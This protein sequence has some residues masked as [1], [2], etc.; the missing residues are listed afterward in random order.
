[1]VFSSVAHSGRS[2][3]EEKHQP[4]QGQWRGRVGV[5][6][7]QGAGVISPDCFL[8][9][10]ETCLCSELGPRPDSLLGMNQEPSTEE[11]TEALGSPLGLS[12]QG[13]APAALL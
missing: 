6:I 9:P 13:K 4:P 12:D 1:M 10:E 5:G 3:T 8:I 11:V 2:H 7:G